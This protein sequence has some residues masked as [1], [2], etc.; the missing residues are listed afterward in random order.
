M[1]DTWFYVEGDKKVGP[2]EGSEVKELLH[3]GVLNEH[4][5]VWRRG[6]ENWIKLRDAEELNEPS[7]TSIDLKNISLTDKILVIKIG[8]D[9]GGQETEYGPFC[10][11]TLKKLASEKRI[12]GQTYIFTPGMD[13]WE[14]ITHT[15]L[16]EIIFG[17]PSEKEV[18]RRESKRRPFVARLFF[19]DNDQVYE[20][21]CRDVSLGGLQVLIQGFPAQVGDTIS[22][23]VHPENNEFCFTA[24]G[25]IVRLLEGGQ[26]FSL[27]FDKLDETATEAINKYIQNE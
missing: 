16:A 11:E 4:T 24:G 27:R 21:V 18:E 15:D 20:G 26:G 6:L 22:M 3:R 5:Y 9:R 7:P 13:D 2:V 23:N 1:A 19:H 8:Q 14:M 10:L 12:N 17:E 25:K